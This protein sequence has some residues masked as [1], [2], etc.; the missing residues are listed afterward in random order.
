M[1]EEIGRG[2]E[3]IITKDGDTVIKDRIP[4]K[5]RLPQIDEKLRKSRT[6]REA[7]VLTKLQD[8]NFYY[9]VP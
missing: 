7:K 5:Y 8:I 9:L 2:A 6:R 4:K 1:T 3:A